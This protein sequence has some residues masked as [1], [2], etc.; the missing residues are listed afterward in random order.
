MKNILIGYYIQFCYFHSIP[1]KFSFA[2]CFQIGSNEIQVCKVFYLGTLAISQTPVYTAHS[3]KDISNI[4]DTPK[5]GKHIKHR[6]PDE[7]VNFVKEHIESFPKIELNYCRANTE[8]EYLDPTLSIKKMYSLY[9]EFVTML[10][11]NL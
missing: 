2:Y 9:V 10:K 1:S 6:I 5:V 8:R 11:R 7:D 3:K 4:P